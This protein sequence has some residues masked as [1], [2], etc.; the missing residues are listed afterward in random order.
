MIEQRRRPQASIPSQS[1]MQFNEIGPLSRDKMLK[2]RVGNKVHSSH[3]PST[4]F[5]H[6]TYPAAVSFKSWLS[7]S[8]ESDIPYLT[9]PKKAE[10]IV[11]R[12]GQGK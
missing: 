1:L 3:H 4:V 5:W 2:S 8:R 12:R 9:C 11:Q 7:T 10:P 6:T